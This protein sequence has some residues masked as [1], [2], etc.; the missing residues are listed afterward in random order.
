LVLTVVLLSA[1][2]GGSGSKA[3][4]QS[5]G[6]GAGEPSLT[7]PEIDI[8]AAA[9]NG[10]LAL[11]TAAIKNRQ[12]ANKAD[13]DGRTALHYAA[14]N[15]HTEVIRLLLKNGAEVNL[16]DSEGRTALMMASSGP[17]PEAVRLLLDNYA[18]PNIRDNKE[19][20]TAIMFAATEGQTEIV[21][22]LLAKGADPTFKDVDGDDAESFATKGGHSDIVTLLRSLKK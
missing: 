15:G 11:V 2:S 21:K 18:D 10:D 20:F 12:K 14:Y 16:K 3:D 22:L 9:L 1:C 13:L 7:G 17:F 5:P 4:K 19:H 8:Y 6:G